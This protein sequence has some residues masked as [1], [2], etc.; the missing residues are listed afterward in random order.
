MLQYPLRTGPTEELVWYV[1]EADAL[2]RVRAE[3]SS[4]VRA[5][6]IA[7]TR[8]WVDAR[9]PRPERAAARRVGAASAARRACRPASPSCSTGSASRAIEA[10]PTT[11]GRASRSR[12]SGGSAAT[13][14]RP[15]PVHAAAGP[16]LCATAT[17][18]SRRPA[19]TPT[20]GQRPAD[21]LLRRVPRPGL[22][23]LALAPPRR[24]VLPL[25]LRPVPRARRARPTAGC[26][27]RPRSWRGWMTRGS[28]PW[29]RSS[30]RSRSWA[31]PRRSGRSSS[32]RRSWPCAAGAG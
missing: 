10:G 31:S 16:R 9:P 29:S 28:G 1:A 27:A 21:P 25:L 32:P 13:A 24:G 11:T 12:P 18:C 20:A 14:S 19:P 3:A 2:R 5:R 23:P 30:S 15:A 4:A 8:R 26:G 17:C 7:E 22:R 6:M